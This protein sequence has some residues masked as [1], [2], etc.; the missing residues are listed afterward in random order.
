MTKQMRALAD[1]DTLLQS[2]LTRFHS[3]PARQ[4]T[5]SDITFAQ[6]RVLWTLDRLRQASPGEVAKRLGISSATATV[7]VTRLVEHERVRSVRSSDDRRRVVLTLRPKGRRVIDEFAMR[8]RTRLERLIA[9]LAPADIE[10]LRDALRTLTEI[11]GSWENN[12]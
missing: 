11:V 1:V 12:P 9:V 6:M 7:L 8:R 3:I 4:R 10:R 2:F 5:S